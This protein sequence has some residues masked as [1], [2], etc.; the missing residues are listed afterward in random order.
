MSDTTSQTNTKPIDPAPDNSFR[1]SL[2][3]V[4]EQ[5]RTKLHAVRRDIETIVRHSSTRLDRDALDLLARSVAILVVE[6]AILDRENN[7]CANVEYAVLIDQTLG[8]GLDRSVA[9][10]LALSPKPMETFAAERAAHIERARVCSDP[11]HHH[12]K[13]VDVDAFGPALGLTRARIR[14]VFGDSRCA[15][16]PMKSRPDRFDPETAQRLNAF[17]DEIG[18]TREHVK[19][20]FAEKGE[21]GLEMLKQDGA[22]ERRRTD[23]KYGAGRPKRGRPVTD[24]GV[25]WLVH[26]KARA[27]GRSRRTIYRWKAREKAACAD[28]AALAAEAEKNGISVDVQIVYDLNQYAPGRRRGSYPEKDL[29]IE[30]YTAVEGKP[31]T[32]PQM[33]KWKQRRLWQ[34]KV[35]EAKSWKLANALASTASPDRDIESG[36]EINQKRSGVNVGTTKSLRPSHVDP[37][38]EIGEDGRAQVAPHGP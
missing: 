30:W 5:R 11:K 19:D 36:V 25:E 16:K 15:I 35:R 20:V 8:I 22:I 18:L 24:F 10:W 34:E 31:P 32:P 37:G 27:S 7:P 4:E 17:A 1:R 38:A 9:L 23:L 21:S 2:N 33:R 14:E 3:R 28:P 29:V 6:I 26:A 12:R 13:L